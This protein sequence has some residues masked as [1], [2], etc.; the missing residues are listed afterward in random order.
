ML[1]FKKVAAD[2]GALY[3]GSADPLTVN[4]LPMVK[5]LAGPAGICIY[6][7]DSRDLTQLRAHIYDT[8]RSS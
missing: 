5:L 1:Q 2:K 6:G 8:P 3:L 7:T 4:E